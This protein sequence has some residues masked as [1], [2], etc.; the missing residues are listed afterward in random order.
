MTWCKIGTFD[1]DLIAKA[2]ELD[3]IKGDER[4]IAHYKEEPE[5]ITLLATKDS[6]ID[7]IDD[8]V[9][10]DAT[11]EVWAPIVDDEEDNDEF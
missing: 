8:T 6:I 10:E 4:L 7:M 5:G 1:R 9:P 11:F 2:I 3:Q